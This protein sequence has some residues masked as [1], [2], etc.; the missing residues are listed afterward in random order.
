MTCQREGLEVNP[1]GAG[2][3]DHT[4]QA[5]GRLPDHCEVSSLDTHALR[6]PRGKYHPHFTDE[7]TVVHKS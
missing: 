2:E 6:I 1:D 3:A 7:E 5:L 4:L